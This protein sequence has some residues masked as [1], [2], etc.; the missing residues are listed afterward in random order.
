M[1]QKYPQLVFALFFIFLS[2]LLDLYP[3]VKEVEAPSANASDVTLPPS[4]IENFRFPL[5]YLSR[6]TEHTAG[7]ELCI[8]P[9]TIF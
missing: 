4:P 7:S 9:L 6:H 5:T 1:F 3:N 8:D 2:S